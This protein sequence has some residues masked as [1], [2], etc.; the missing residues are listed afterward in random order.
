MTPRRTL[1][2]ILLAGAVVLALGAAVGTYL[3]FGSNTPPYE[4]ERSVYVTPNASFE[5]VVDSLSSSGVLNTE[6]TFRWIAN[7][8]GWRQQIKAGHYSFASGASN[9]ELLDVLRKGLQTPKRIAIPPGTTPEVTAAVAAREMAFEADDFLEALRDSSLAEELGTD[10]DHLFSFMLPETYHFYW[11]SDASDVVRSIKQNFDRTFEGELRE[12][13]DSLDLSVE[14]VLNLASIIQWETGLPEEKPKVAG[15]YLN[16]LR[17]GMALQADPTVQFAVMEEEGSKRRLLYADYD[18]DHP[19]NTYLFQGLPPSP[20]TN[21]SML[22]I[23]AV[24]T[25][26]D[27]DYL[28]F[29]ANGDGGHTFSQTLQEHNRAAREFHE[30]MRERRNGR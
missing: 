8:T 26:D 5:T 23:E 7:A 22:A 20:I 30:V 9:Y 11:L 10:A 1:I 27:H 21:P 2:S 16:R 17:I 4:G 25:A 13:A 12:R 19:Y 28:Y 24:L 15:V 29:V 18:I 14:E 3:V 6:R